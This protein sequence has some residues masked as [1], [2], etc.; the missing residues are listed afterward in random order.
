MSATV[1]FAPAQCHRATA[2][3]SGRGAPSHC[4]LLLPPRHRRRARGSVRAVPP[5]QSSLPQA[6]AAAA[7]LP[8]APVYGTAGDVK[9]ALYGALDGANRGIFGMTSAKRSEIH[10]LV[11][12]LESRN[13]TPEPTAKLQDKVPTASVTCTKSV[14]SVKERGCSYHGSHQ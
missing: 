1:L 7:A 3:T 6:P 5:E 11:E 2:T 9:A 13:P 10:G 14:R 4:A 12:L 8:L